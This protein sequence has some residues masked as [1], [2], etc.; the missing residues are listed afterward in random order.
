MDAHQSIV[1]FA[2]G[3]ILTIILHFGLLKQQK[4]RGLPL[5]QLGSAQCA[6]AVARQTG[7]SK[8]PG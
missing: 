4:E 2:G 1:A 3:R 6:T 8:R 7:T 5:Q